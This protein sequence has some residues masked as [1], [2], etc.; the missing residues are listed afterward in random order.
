MFRNNDATLKRW[1]I[2]EDILLLARDYVRSSPSG[3]NIPVSEI[4]EYV[5]SLIFQVYERSKF[6]KYIFQ[7]ML[8]QLISHKFHFLNEAFSFRLSKGR[9]RAEVRQMRRLQERKQ[10]TQRSQEWY[11]KR[12]NQIGAS[13]LSSVFNKNPFCSQKKY[14]LKKTIPPPPPESAEAAAAFTGNKHTQHGVRF[15]DIAIMLYERRRCVRVHEFGSIDDEN[16]SFISASPDGITDDGIMLEIKCP[17]E[18]EIIGLPPVYYWYQMQQQMHVCNLNQC[19]FLECKITEYGSWDEFVQDGTE[20]QSS[21]GMEKGVI[22]EYINP[23][24]TSPRDRLGYLYPDSVEMSLEAIY[25][26]DEQMKQQLDAQGLVYSQI[27]PWRLEQYSCIAVYRHKVW[28]DTH[29]QKICEFWET[30]LHMREDV[31]I[32]PEQWLASTKRKPR[33]NCRTRKLN[34][35]ECL[36]DVEEDP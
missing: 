5:L 12:Y 31:R 24:A 14:I 29:I 25:A 18:R 2:E 22:L 27:I 35:E 7:E 34:F 3:T 20:Y 6:K 19:D 33:T 4:A 8:E 36:I 10:E 11:A 9:K 30:I 16:L 23:D 15:E 13:E 32:S 26:W 1:K 28:W 17:Y 21:L